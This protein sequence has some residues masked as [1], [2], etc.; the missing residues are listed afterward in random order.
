MSRESY[1]QYMTKRLKEDRLNNKIFIAGGCSFTYNNEMTWA[2]KIAE[3]FNVVNVGSCAAGNDYIA[4]SVIHEM[5]KHQNQVLICQWSGIHRRSYYIDKNSI[6]FNHFKRYEWPDWA[7]DYQNVNT[8]AVTQ[9]EFWIKTGGNNITHP[10][11]SDI[12]HKNYVEP[13]LKHFYSDE[14]ALVET[15]ENILRV[16]YY[17]KAHHVTNYMFWWK[18]EIENY[19][20]GK[21]SQELYDQIK[22]NKLTIWLPSLGDWCVKNT[23]LSQTDL[24]QGY[25]PTKTQHD[26]YAEQVI[27][28]SL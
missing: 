4:R 18:T 22:K 19:K 11:S 21:Y 10:G 8:D 5:E 12:I 17:C 9:D 2:G 25:H 1:S 16:Q 3:K 20:L 23:D 13:Y 26:R 7:G 15:F 24:E 6:F 14:Q 27:L 28:K